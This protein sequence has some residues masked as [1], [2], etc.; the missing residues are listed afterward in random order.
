M[1][2]IFKIGNFSKFFLCACLLNQEKV[3]LHFEFYEMKICPI[4]HRFLYFMRHNAEIYVY[5]NIFLG[6]KSFE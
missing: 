6:S 4:F 1:L 2:E 3:M 5:L